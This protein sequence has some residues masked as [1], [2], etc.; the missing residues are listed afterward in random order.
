MRM[1]NETNGQTKEP[2]LLDK[3]HAEFLKAGGK[4]PDAKT[5]K[6]LL[7]SWRA[8]SEARDKAEAAFR[9]AQTAESDAVAAIIKAR[10][11]GRVKID[12]EVHVPMSRGTTVFF[13]KEGGSDVPSFG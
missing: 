5:G 7:G 9:K 3:L 11:K 13:R 8:A 4:E 10:G 12:G 2:S 6:A 1:A